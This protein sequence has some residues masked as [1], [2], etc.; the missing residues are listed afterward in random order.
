MAAQK[1]NRTETKSVAIGASQGVYGLFAAYDYSPWHA[2]GEFIDN[3]VSS[4]MSL[5]TRQRTAEPLVVSVNW[6]SEFGSGASAGKLVVCDNAGGIS[7]KDLDRAFQLATPPPDLSRLNQFGVGLKVAACWFARE[8]TVETSAY[9]EAVKRTIKWRTKD[10]VEK[11]LV[12]LPISATKASENE[13]YT[14]ITLT[15]LNH[16]PNHPRSIGKIKE[17]LPKAFRKFIENRSLSIIWNG[18]ELKYDMPEVLI[19]SHYKTEA[20]PISWDREFKIRLKNKMEVKG[21]ARLFATWSRSHTALNYFWRGRLIQGNIE[22]FYRPVELFGTG[23]SFRSARLY[24]ELDASDFYVTAD[25]KAIDFGR[26]KTTEG[27]IIDKVRV[28]LSGD[29]FPILQQG[30]NYRSGNTG[31]ELIPVIEKSLQEAKEVA[32]QK[33]ED[34]LDEEVVPTARPDE[35][36]KRSKKIASQLIEHEHDGQKVRFKVECK[37]AGPLEPWIQVQWGDGRRPEHRVTINLQHTFVKRHI[38]KNT[39]PIFIGL[40][41]ST[42]YGE[43][44]TRTTH[45]DAATLVVTHTDQFLRIMAQHNQKVEYGD[46]D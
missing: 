30:E 7:S 5:T 4:W 40:A 43:F 21:R 25:K 45:G 22:P 19:A 11:N 9:G 8:W 38:V 32:E 6:N 46:E 27:E 17:F 2:L 1:Q 12:S 16:P 31:H 35:P 14:R 20:K 26:S 37:D 34:Y 36:I 24:I 42:V 3:S 18:E 23:N 41:V 29:S 13:H 44:K 39:V 28:A 10:I 33:A 15:N